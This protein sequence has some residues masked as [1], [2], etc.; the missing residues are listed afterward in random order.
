MSEK[1][2]KKS[3]FAAQQGWNPSYITKLKHQGR[4]V[5]CKD[6]PKLIDVDATLANLQCTGDP[7]KAALR[8]HHAD[9]RI[10]KNVTAH[11]KPDAPSNDQPPANA[12]PKYWDNK[13][14][15]EGALANLAELELE[16]QSGNYVERKKVEAMAFYTGRLFRDRILGLVPRLAMS[17]AAM[18]DPN[19]IEL[20]LKKELRG[21]MEGMAKMT[22]DDLSRLTGD[23]LPT[24]MAETEGDERNVLRR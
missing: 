18:T 16:K 17:L 10:E 4:L 22:A 11:V 6:D 21:A 5:Y 15:R 3:A 2:L 1:Y 14:R 12:D 7:G 19:E 9:V 8:Q 24:R 13:T 20:E 23:T